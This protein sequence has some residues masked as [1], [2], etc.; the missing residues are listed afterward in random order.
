MVG[1][2]TQL[3]LMIRDTHAH[4]VIAVPVFEIWLNKK[5]GFII[6]NDS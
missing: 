2:H 4:S 1:S 3:T 5:H 6:R